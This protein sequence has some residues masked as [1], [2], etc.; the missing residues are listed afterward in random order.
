MR[1]RRLWASLILGLVVLSFYLVWARRQRLWAEAELAEVDR[2]FA[3][4]RFGVAQARLTPLTDSPSA[5]DQAFYWIG[6]CE[7]AR[8]RFDAALAAWG[9]VAASSPF[10]DRS[11]LAEARVMANTGRLS[12]A[13][14]ILEALP[15]A[16]GPDGDQARNALD[17]LYRLEGRLDESLPLVA[18][19]WKGAA[20]PGYI[21]R[22][23]YLIDN[24]AYPIDFVRKNLDAGDRDDP[25]VW[26]GEANLAIWTGRYDDAAKWLDR[27]AAKAPGDLPVARANLRLAVAADDLDR[28]RAAVAALPAGSLA[29]VEVLRLR[30]WLAARQPDV[31]IERKALVA[32]LD[33]EPGSIAAWDRLAELAVV[34][35]DR[36]EAERNR[37]RKAEINV[38]RERYKTLITRDDRSD[39]A[40]ELAD[41]A[42]K[43][44]RSLEARGWEMIRDGKEGLEP[45]ETESKP[46]AVAPGVQLADLLSAARPGSARSR[47]AQPG[48]TL[49]FRDDAAAAGLTFEHDNGHSSERNPPPTEAM[50][51]GVALLDYDKDGRLDVYVVQGGPFPASPTAL[52]DGDRLYRNLG[53]G[54]FEDVTVQAGISRFPGGYGHGATVADYDNNGFPD[55]FVTRWGSYALYRNTGKGG[56]EDATRAAGLDGFRDW[57]TSAA[58]AD[59]DGDGD[60]D[61]YVCHYLLYD[62]S[63]PKRCAHPGSPTAR[64]CNPIDFPS[65]PDHVF[66]NDGGRFVDVTAASGFVDPDGRGLGVSAGDFDGDGRIDL[67]V[68]N[69]MS[70]NYLFRNKGGFQFEEVGQLAGVSAS[71]DGGYKAGMG[72]AAGD[73]DGDGLP[74]LAVTNYFGESTTF[75]RNLGRGFFADHS[76]SIGIAAP[77]RSLLG[78]GIAFVDVDNDGWLD[79]LSA[80]GH[81]LDERPKIPWTMPLN[82]LRAV[83]GGKLVD[84]SA[85]A[86][87]AFQRL[88]L[89]RG[90]AVGDLDD[91]GRLDALVVAQNEPLIFLHNQTEAAGRIIRFRLEG[92][93]SNRDAVGASVSVFAGGRKRV[94][95]RRGGGSYQSASDPRLQ[96]GLGDAKAV[97]WVEVRWPSG[98]VERHE[99]LA[100]DREYLLREGSP[101][102]E[103]GSPIGQSRK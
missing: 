42:A 9:R 37:R 80:N 34:R 101:P 88:H 71:S 22:R 19:T 69:D 51:G 68:A 18:E 63:N 27:C 25:R 99:A 10:S 74:D 55:L 97:D 23:I 60:L 81:I 103:T 98:L 83:P 67:F 11:R 49:A 5:R 29:D 4:G 73:L 66:R 72:V 43:L 20:D 38:I 75:Y 100:V 17:L 46:S 36:D 59:L 45:L 21:L 6:R 30:A 15:R 2:L 65:L 78:F 52:N 41:L 24:S 28:A 89:G 7:E 70:A 16:G 26:L 33:R 96:F 91:D 57:P 77:T 85:T 14:D 48:A 32:W 82:L 39:F 50:S 54:R 64:T 95:E 58:F 84:V 93:R 47:T 92:T 1:S 8:G 62:P 94:D 90:L 40:P 53:G 35:G 13:G 79:V 86:G 56:F 44:G 12:R 76:T 61:L 31:E 3:A 102:V 87:E